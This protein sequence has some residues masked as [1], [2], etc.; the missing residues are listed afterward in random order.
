V[1][2]VEVYDF[3]CKCEAYAMRMQIAITMRVILFLRNPVKWLFS[4]LGSRTAYPTKR[5]RAIKTK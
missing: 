3:E 5:Y 4:V 2:T 1:E